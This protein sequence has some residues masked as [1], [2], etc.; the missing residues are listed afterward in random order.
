MKPVILVCII[1]LSVT[2]CGPSKQNEAAKQN[3]TAP[4]IA[5]E[6]NVCDRY[7][8]FV[9][10]YAGKQD[11]AIKQTLLKRLDFDKQSLPTRDKKEADEYCKTSLERMERMA[12]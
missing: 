2:A 7:F 8:A 5:A 9:E 10:S 4:P 6:G 12:G 1:A 11:A 3:G